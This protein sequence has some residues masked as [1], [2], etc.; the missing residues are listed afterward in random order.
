MHRFLILGG[1]PRQLYLT[2][3]LKQSG[4]EASHYY[5]IS[6]FF[7]LK[8]A[9]EDSHIILCPIPFTK[10]KKNIYSHHPLPGLEIDDFLRFLR[11]GHILFGGNI[12]FAVKE[13]CKSKD[14]PCHDF[15]NMDEVACKNAIATAEGAIAEA[16]SLSPINLHGSSCLVTGWGRCAEALAKKLKGM[17]TRVTV[18]AR[19]QANLTRSCFYNYNTL[20]LKHLD[21][22]IHEYDFIFNTIPA[23][24][25]DSSLANHIQPDTVIIDIASAPGGVDFDACRRHSIRAKL[26]PGLP[27]TYSPI[28]SAE[29][30]YEAVM[31]QL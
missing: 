23:M 9:M 13:H 25:L 2:R 3:F 4:H 21:S 29:I 5:E 17:D 30:L 10:D 7:S 28:T 20:L 1:D 6:T 15:M 27:G 18:T 24:V 26:C 11:Q 12:P 8:E 19:S 14:I 16:I 31:K 22:H